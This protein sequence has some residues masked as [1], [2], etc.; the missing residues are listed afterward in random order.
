MGKYGQTLPSLC[1]FGD[2]QRAFPSFTLLYLAK[3]EIGI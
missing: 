1:R 2:L 3:K